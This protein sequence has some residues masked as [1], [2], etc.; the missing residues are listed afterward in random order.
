MKL[1]L[2]QGGKSISFTAK[3]SGNSGTKVPAIIAYGGASIPIP[4]GVATI[5]FNNDD[6]AAQ[7]DKSSRGKGKFYN[8]Y[9]ASHS[10][11]AMSA[12]AWGVSRII[13]ALESTTG[14][15][16]DT[17]KIG[18]TGCSRNGKGAMVAGAFDDRI[19]LTVRTSRSCPTYSNH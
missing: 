4:A 13:D 11:G 3:I 6:M 15:N 7:Q 12:W 10:A 1:T 5:T 9:G 19:A 17:T 18:V 2:F 8:L 14:H 16:I